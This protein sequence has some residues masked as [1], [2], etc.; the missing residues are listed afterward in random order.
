MADAVRPRDQDE[1]LTRLAPLLAGFRE[2]R[3]Q[4]DE[5]ASFPRANFE[6]LRRAGLLGS[7]V[8]AE[9]GGDDFW[10]KDFVEYYEVYERIA[11][12]DPSTAQLYQIQT[13]GAGMLAWHATPEQRRK[14]LPD[15]VGRGLLIASVGSEAD[16]HAK[17]PE[18]RAELRETGN[19]WRLSCHKHFASLGPGA[20]YLLVWVAVPG[21][22]TW[23]DRQLYV[24]V[25]RG[26][27]GVELIDEWDTM[28]M[29]ATVSW[30]V[31]L[32]D[33]EVA[34]DAII[35][36]PG[37]WASDPRT[38]T[39]G[40]VTNH[41]GCAE[42]AFALVKEYVRERPY[43][44]QNPVIQ[45]AVGEMSADL[46]VVRATLYTC[47][48]QWEEASAGGWDPELV[49]RAE[50]LGLQ[51]LHVSKRVA[52]DVSSRAF[53]VCGARASFRLFP[54]D[55]TYRD[56]R[57]FTLHHR[58]FDYMARVA[59]AVLEGADKAELGSYLAPSGSARR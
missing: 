13:H 2:R 34:D 38:F 10:L 39:L 15:V 52:L 27:P 25:P 53:D 22:G 26:A 23:A 24:L 36:R 44:A 18:N 12:A 29:R 1:R 30:A 48:R 42:G 46:A 37:A 47:A 57:T 3:R 33:F 31:K 43:L 55:M 11:A 40:Y 32:T 41:L 20:D 14:Y 49:R 6:E 17:G 9:F 56:V 58:D 35:G 45:L 21:A 16:L 19:G 5:T 7:S 8:P 54:F 4:Y 28:G 59:T 50:V 51:A